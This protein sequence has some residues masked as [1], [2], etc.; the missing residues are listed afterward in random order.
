MDEKIVILLVDDDK[1]NLKLAQIILKEEGY[2]VAAALSGE[3]AI[4]YLER[5]VPDLILMDLNMPGLDGFETIEQIKTMPNGKN[6]PFIFL[7]A[8][9]DVDSEIRGF[10][11]G[12]E[13]FIRKP[14]VNSIVKKRVRRAIESYNLRNNL[15]HEVDR[16]TEKVN[17]KRKEL[18]QL[19]IE[20]IR[21]L[22][23]TIDTKD[24]YTKG[25]SSRVAQYSV[26][27][28]QAMGWEEKEI[29]NLR[30]MALLHDVGKIGIPDRVLNKP[31]K[32]EPDEYEIIKNHTV[33]GDGIL[34]EVS[35]LESISKVARHH[36]ERYD[37]KGY[38][39]RL[40]GAEIELEARIVGIADAYDAMSSNR[41]YR[42]ALPND[43]IREELVKGRG[44][45]FDPALL[46]LFLELFD[47]GEV[48]QPAEEVN[49]DFNLEYITSFMN[50]L[51][52]EGEHEGALKL[53]HKELVKMYAYLKAMGDRYNNKFCVALISLECSSENPDPDQMLK[54]MAAMEYS[55]L[56][57]IRK[58]DMTSR[59]TE[60][61]QLI[62]LTETNLENAKMVIERIFASYYKNCLYTDIKPV[63]EIEDR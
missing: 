53:S 59:V 58:S 33:Y 62:I 3:Q 60:T 28:A 18:E 12:A 47:K 22:A 40:A 5:N 26:L 14:F 21:T 41:V 24:P 61:Q 63:Y 51:T 54:A 32:L 46:D 15:Q 57:T 9:E 10:E 39:D 20:I 56:Q 43:V 44:T 27:L 29:E 2:T 30:I 42:N 17:K 6:I 4:S 25:H 55:I 19:S 38:P 50:T 13:D 7:T 11:M 16:Q 34:K 36:H 1:M 49:R 52:A 23:A 35:S 48:M 37:G 8:Q 45:Q 31:G